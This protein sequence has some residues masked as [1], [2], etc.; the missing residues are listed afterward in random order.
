MSIHP[1]AFAA[2]NLLGAGKTHVAYQKL[3]TKARQDAYSVENV[4]A[5]VLKMKRELQ[6]KDQQEAIDLGHTFRREFGYVQ[7]PT[8]N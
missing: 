8:Q 4:N 2:G 5:K 6:D 3:A 1:D 7:R